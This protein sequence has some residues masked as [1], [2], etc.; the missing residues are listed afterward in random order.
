MSLEILL[1]S[2]DT[3]VLG[4]YYVSHSD[5]NLFFHPSLYPPA[6][7]QPAAVCY[8]VSMQG[9]RCYNSLKQFKKIYY[10]MRNVPEML[11][12]YIYI[13]FGGGEWGKK[14]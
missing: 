1:A 11:Y 13:F 7:V 3:F 6:L 4:D 12:I 5:S 8:A 10:S 14:Y 2:A 9:D